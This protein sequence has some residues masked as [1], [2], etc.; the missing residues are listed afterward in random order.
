MSSTDVGGTDARVRHI[1]VYD[2]PPEPADD[3]PTST[4]ARLGIVEATSMT[5]PGPR[6]QRVQTLVYEGCITLL[7]GDSG[8]G[9]SYLTQAIGMCVAAGLPF[10]RLAVE[11]GRVLFVDSELDEDEFARRAYRLARGLGLVAPP[12]G[13]FYVRLAEPLTSERGHAWFRDAARAVDADLVILDS[14]SVASAGA[15]LSDGGDVVSILNGIKRVGTLLCVD[16]IQWSGAGGNQSEAHPLGS[17]MKKAVV[18]SMIQ[19]NGSM[20]GAVTLRPSKASFDELADPIHVAITHEPT[21]IRISRLALTDGR[22]AGSDEHMRVDERVV[23]HLALNGPARPEAIGQALGRTG[24][25]V[26]NVLTKLRI[27]GRA[28]P[29]GD[30]TWRHVPQPD[31]N[32]THVTPDVTVQ[33]S[34]DGDTLEAAQ[35]SS[36][37]HIPKEYDDVTSPTGSVDEGG[38]VSWNGVD[39]TQ[40]EANVTGRMA[41]HPT[42]RLPGG[43]ECSD[44]GRLLDLDEQDQGHCLPERGCASDR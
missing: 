24:S 44:C 35:A 25:Y 3:D 22:M 17:F 42:P 29:C 40:Y 39:L 16:H 38:A 2:L 6:R 13:L 23:W 27:K 8:I 5:E 10:L 20:G 26:Q 43:T 14:L 15:R 30:G 12:A 11:P 37:R 31:P 32:V 34:T 36:H 28:E 21:A 41:P 33:V 9:K 19:V 7:Y 18:R 1:P 4:L